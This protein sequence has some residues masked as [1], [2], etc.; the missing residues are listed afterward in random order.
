[1]KGNRAFVLIEKLSYAAFQPY[2][3]NKYNNIA[4]KEPDVCK[5]HGLFNVINLT[6]FHLIILSLLLHCMAGLHFSLLLFFLPVGF[7]GNPI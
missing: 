7:K 5:F 2:G 6:T 3:N 1:M 4:L